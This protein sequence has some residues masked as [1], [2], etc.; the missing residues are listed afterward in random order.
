MIKFLILTVVLTMYIFGQDGGPRKNMQIMMKWQLT[1]YLD[2]TEKQADKFFPKMNDHEKKMKELN[3]QIRNL[4]EN[5]EL[6]IE[7]GTSN[8]M[9]N[10]TNIEK[11]EKFEKE[12]IELR[13]IYL[14]SLEGILEPSQLSKLMVFEKKFKKTLKDELRKKPRSVN[15][16]G[17]EKKTYRPR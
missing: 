7:N 17:I 2:I 13:S 3:F 5:I 12:K 10:R 8:R 6:N 15:K 11:I 14:F 9:I 16:K 1:E 4:R